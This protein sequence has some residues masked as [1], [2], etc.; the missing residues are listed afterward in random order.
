MSAKTPA[1]LQKDFREI[2]G[3]GRYPRGRGLVVRPETIEEVEPA[4]FE[5]VIARGQG[6]S[7]GN[8]AMNEG[9]VVMMTEKLDRVISFDERNGWLTAEAGMTLDEVFRN[10][11]PRG[12]FPSVTPGTRFVSLGGCVAADVHGKNHHHDGTFGANVREIEIAMA[13]GSRVRCSP[14][15]NAELFFATLG[16]MGLTGVITEVTYRLI[17]VESAYVVVRHNKA[18][19]LDASLSLLEGEEWDDR[20]SVAW[21][22]CLA[23]GRALGR[24]VLMSGHHARRE[25]ISGKI[26][27]PLKLKERGKL[28]LPFDFPQWV[29]NSLTISAFNRFYYL[30]QGAKRE[31]F[32]T[33]YATFFHPL[34]SI[35]NWNRMYGRRGF[36]QYQCVLPPQESSEGL[37]KLLEELARERRASF[38]AVLKRFGAQNQGMLSFPME[39]YTLALD[40]PVSDGGLFPFLDRLDEIVLKHGGRVYLA[41]DTRVKA[42]TFRRM[43]PRFSEWEQV[44][45]KVDAENR[46]N[47]DLARMLEIGTQ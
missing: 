11:L 39:G 17:P 43:Y 20:Y 3:W 44:K 33:D 32:V 25:E 14:E 29:L 40:M 36:I 34:D 19:D 8:A 9:G 28:N 21:I 6:R 1:H 10:F 7:Y 18:R 16:G 45:R 37:R 23:R 31:P 30:W 5:S 15:R 12:W 47:S 13:D 22:D 24:S 46:F 38:L 35:N 2:S 42:E 41:K 4:I 26:E 27:E